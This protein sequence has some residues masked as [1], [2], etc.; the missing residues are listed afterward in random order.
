[1][2]LMPRRLYGQ[3]ILIVSLILIATIVTYGWFTGRKQAENYLKAMKLNATVMAG[4]LAI[5]CINYLVISDYAGMELF[6]LRSAEFPDILGIQ[7]CDQHG[8]VLSDIVHKPGTS[9]V[10]R[11]NSPPSRAPAPVQTDVRIED[12]QMII[13]Q[14]IISGSLLGWVKVTY[15]MEAISEMQGII[16]GNSI[17]WGVSG[18]LASFVLLML[19]LR[20]PAHA[21]QRL[22]DFARR[23]DNLK[24]EQIPVEHGSIEIEQLGESLNHASRELYST[25]RQLIAERER[26]AVTLQ[27]IGDGVIAT[28]TEGRVILFNKVA[29]ELAGWLSQEAGG[30]FLPEVFHI[31]NEKTRRPAENPVERVLKTGRIVGLANHTALISRDGTERSIADSGAPIVDSDG[32]II[33]VVLVFRDVTE[34]NKMEAEIIRAQKLESLGVLAGGIAHDFNNILTAILGNVSLAKMYA[35]PGD[36]ISERLAVAEKATL[37]ARDL[38]QQLLTFSRGGVPILKTAS[39]GNLLRETACFSLRGSNIRCDVHLSG[40]LCPVEVDEGQMS[41]VIQNLIINAQQAMPEGGIIKVSAEN[42]TLEK[43]GDL[44]LEKG[45]YVKIIIEDQGIGIPEEHL[46]KIF[47][48]FFTTKEQGSGLGLAT[49]YS[50]IKK[51]NG[52]ITVS[53][54]AG[55]G[56]TFSLYLPASWKEEIMTEETGES[57]SFEGTG[58][59]LVMDDEEYIREFV[60]DM[61]SHFGYTVDSAKNGGE[62][63]DLYKRAIESGRP[64]DVVIMDLTVPGDMGGRETMMKLVEIDPGVKAIVSSG[65]SSDPILAEFR[66]H[67]FSGVLAKPYKS[68]ELL[69]ALHKIITKPGI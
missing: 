2:G 67:G 35:N 45:N 19:V 37:R 16:W 12:G 14:P 25:E 36:G 62:T 54:R 18:I 31:I 63:L 9:P 44:P 32:K 8:Q 33:G 42:I 47:D 68:E 30:K 39:I 26:L 7:V 64:Y 41:Q 46:N 10:A 6:L 20:P 4:N 11:F 13:R 60:S 51:H 27:S 40:N 34:K 43:D 53:S 28:D 52:H 17:F 65:Y 48:P 29:E 49:V 38:A 59:V 56:T 69:A 15:S 50:I 3:L 1:M 58:R 23:L 57:V 5:G 24:G 22:T 61:L 55:A 21:I 66:K